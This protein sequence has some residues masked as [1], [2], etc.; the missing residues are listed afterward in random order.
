MP[1]EILLTLG[2]IAIV[3]DKDFERISQYRWNASYYLRKDMWVAIRTTGNKYKR[4]I[5][6]MHREI[7][8]LLKGDGQI[9]D[10]RDGNSLNNTRLNLR[11]VSNSQNL[12]NHRG[13]R[14]GNSSGF[15]GVYKHKK[16]NIWYPA[17][18]LDDKKYYLGSY[19]NKRIAAVMRD[20]AALHL[21]GDFA[22]LNFPELFF[23]G[24]L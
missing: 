19:K 14:K 5:F 16:Y 4:N 8:G 18:M 7:L 15:I 1:K 17:V 9:V 3:D 23:N 20:K 22:S 2:K 13:L 11:I 6:L 10:H 24:A 12:Q 21:H